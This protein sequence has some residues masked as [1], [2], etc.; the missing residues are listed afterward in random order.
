VDVVDPALL[1]LDEEE[2]DDEDEL[3]RV[4]L[5]GEI[6]GDRL[7]L[8]EEAAAWLFEDDGLT[9]LLAIAE[10]IDV[11]TLSILSVERFSG[12]SNIHTCLRRQNQSR[13]RCS[14]M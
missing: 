1:V 13:R 2:E 14:G 4:E 5:L 6:V 10:G 12:R 9:E 11:L 3:A 8:Y 7:A